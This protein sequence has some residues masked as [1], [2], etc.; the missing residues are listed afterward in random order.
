MITTIKLT[1]GCGCGK[2]KPTPITPTPITPPST[3]KYFTC[4]DCDENTLFCEC[5]D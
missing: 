3:S 4:P 1:K 2:P 5:D